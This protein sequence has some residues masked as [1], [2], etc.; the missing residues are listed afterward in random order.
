MAAPRDMR[1]RRIDSQC[2]TAKR[3]VMTGLVP[4]ISI[5]LAKP[6]HGHRDRRAKPGDDE[7]DRSR[8]A[9]CIRVVV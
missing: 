8:D 5:Q 9:I 1:T 7:L 2:Q 4:V 3:S 6:C